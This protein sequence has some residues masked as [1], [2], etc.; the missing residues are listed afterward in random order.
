[1]SNKTSLLSRT[2]EAPKE[3][4]PLLQLL[5]PLPKLANEAAPT[6]SGDSETSPPSTASLLS[7]PSS[8]T[9]TEDTANANS[10]PF[11]LVR[12]APSTSDPEPEPELSE[13]I[14]QSSV[15]SESI[16]FEQGSVI[17]DETLPTVE[18][19]SASNNDALSITFIAVVAAVCCAVAAAVFYLRGK[20]KHDRSKFAS[21]T[22]ESIVEPTSDPEPA[23]DP[24]PTSRNDMRNSRS[25]S[26][27][28]APRSADT[29][30]RRPTAPP[31]KP[32]KLVSPPT[33][34][35]NTP[36]GIKAPKKPKKRL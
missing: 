34:A 21:S 16:T 28:S 35:K 1:M 36:S 3:A 7:S 10:S 17:A 19:E 23:S 29:H 24:E 20:Q 9:A 30:A 5:T 32:S 4:E 26:T 33:Q 11:N 6:K 14:E 27:L 12:S 2:T 18:T 25:G 15:T 8:T 22:P 31:Q 13:Y